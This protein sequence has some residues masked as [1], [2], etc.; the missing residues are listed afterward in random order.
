MLCLLVWSGS[1]LAAAFQNL[2]FE[3]ATFVPI[4]GD[5]H[6]RVQFAPALPGWIGYVGGVPQTLALHNVTFIS[7]A[8]IGVLDS[9]WPYG[10]LIQGN[11]TAFLQPVLLDTGS[12]DTSLAQIGRVPLLAQSLRFNAIPHAD[13]FGFPQVGDPIGTFAVMLGGQELPVFALGSGPN[14][15]TMFGVDVLAWAGQTAELRFTTFAAPGGRFIGFNNLFLDSIEF[16]QVPVP[17]PGALAL[18]GLGLAALVC[19]LKRRANRMP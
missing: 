12:I 4:P 18:L 17:E 1:A 5:P 6:E 14:N 13:P 11:S 16:S 15:S 9:A 7:V 10:G 8:A 19:R 2:D 3:S